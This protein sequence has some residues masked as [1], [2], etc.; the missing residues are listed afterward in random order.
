MSIFRKQK[1]CN[2]SEIGL[3][4]ISSKP[5]FLI[6]NSTRTL[7]VIENSKK[8]IVMEL[9]DNSKSNSLQKQAIKESY[10]F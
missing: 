9:R 10:F 2:E 6:I 5:D 3:R 8:V 7:K 4:L 1:R